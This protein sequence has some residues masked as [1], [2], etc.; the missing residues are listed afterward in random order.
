MLV[1]YIMSMTRSLTNAGVIDY[2]YD[3]KFPDPWLNCTY[4]A[5]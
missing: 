1:L 5:L 4:R 2:E 3:K